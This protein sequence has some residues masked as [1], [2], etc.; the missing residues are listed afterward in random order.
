M[1]YSSLSAILG[2]N[3][4][5]PDNNFLSSETPP[6]SSSVPYG[7]QFT[8]TAWPA[9]PQQNIA[10]Q[11]LVGG[12]HPMAPVTYDSY[13]GVHDLQ[14]NSQSSLQNNMP[15]LRNGQLVQRPFFNAPGSSSLGSQQ[16][17]RELIL[18]VSASPESS[19]AMPDV[20]FSPQQPFTQTSPGIQPSQPSIQT[21]PSVPPPAS[22][23]STL[24]RAPNTSSMSTSGSDSPMSSAPAGDP[25]T[26]APAAR[27]AEV[28]S[29][30]YTKVTKSYSYIKS[31]Q[32]LMS[33]LYKKYAKK[34][35]DIEIRRQCVFLS[36]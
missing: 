6:A 15:Y 31:Y 4:Y 1:E 32:F 5:S 19:Y 28:A 33:F 9:E 34:Q 11:A 2:V 7:Q 18:P 21:Q 17:G 25:L 12:T 8:N 24:D 10:P 14:Q 3:N 22:A 35:R 27:Q 20:G 36:Y 26:T 13:N 16:N 29:D 30:V 23:P